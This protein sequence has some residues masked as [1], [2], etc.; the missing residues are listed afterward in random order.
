MNM[1]DEIIIRLFFER[2]EQA[3]AETG[4]KYG[5]YCFAVANNI[6][7]DP[8]DAEECVNDTWLRAWNAIPPKRP[9]RLKYYLLK[10]A[11]NLALDRYESRRAQKRGGG[12]VELAIEEL[13]GVSDG[14]SDVFG[15]FM[16]R[17]L[18]E[19]IADFVHD[20]PEKERTVFI[21]RYFHLDSVPDI[22]KRCGLSEKTVAPML[23]RTRKKLKVFLEKEMN[24]N[25]RQ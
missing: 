12:D 19:C 2:D 1:D 20:L 5:A 15:E 24:E 3:L 17:K 10:I 25:D 11:R 14:R 18:E 8:R 13:D 23:S 16:A 21:R 9:K 22:A 4:A 7:K 6:L